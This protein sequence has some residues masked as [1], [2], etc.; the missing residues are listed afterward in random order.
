MEVECDFNGVILLMKDNVSTAQMLPSFKP[1]RSSHQRTNTS[2][3]NVRGNQKL[4][5]INKT[6]VSRRRCYNSPGVGIYDPKL[7]LVFRRNPQ[8]AVSKDRRFASTERVCS[9]YRNM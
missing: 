5:T 7:S 6:N 4:E 3:N 9:A 8:P 1:S 2:V